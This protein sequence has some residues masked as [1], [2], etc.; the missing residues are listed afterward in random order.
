[1][2]EKTQ[3]RKCV[4]MVYEV[5]QFASSDIEGHVEASSKHQDV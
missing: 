5:R 3:S 2:K 4:K 1:M